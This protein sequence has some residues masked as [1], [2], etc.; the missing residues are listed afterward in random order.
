MYPTLASPTY[1][2]QTQDVE[3]TAD[4]YFDRFYKEEISSE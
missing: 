2:K 4:Q 1:G 3:K